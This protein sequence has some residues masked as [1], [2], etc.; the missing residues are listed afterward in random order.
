MV[1]AM[2][3]IQVETRCQHMIH[4]RAHA[5]TIR[6][7]RANRNESEETALSQSG[8]AWKIVQL[9]NSRISQYIHSSRE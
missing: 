6:T 7:Q 9:A 8:R 2:N 1:P 4:I 3:K 5:W